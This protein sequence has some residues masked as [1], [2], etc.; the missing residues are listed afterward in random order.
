MSRPV[1]YKAIADFNLQQKRYSD[2]NDKQLH[3][4]IAEVK[5]NHSRAGEVM[6]QGHLRAQGIHVQRSR[7]R[8]AIHQ[9]DPL[10]PTTRRR[11][12]IRRRV[13][14]VPCPNYLWHIDGNH[15]LI[16][17]RMVIHH[18]IDG[19][20]R[21]VVFCHCS[22]NNKAATVLSLFQE[23]VRKYGRPFRIRTDLGGENV[24]VWTDMVNAWGEDSRSVVVG[25]SV[26]NQRIER[27]NRAINEQE[28][29]GLKEE[30]YDLESEGL[31]DPLN[32]TDIFCLHYIY[33]P[34][35]NQ[36]ISEFVEAH[37]NHGVSTEAC[38]TPAQIFYLNLHLTAFRVG[39]SAEDVWAGVR[40]EDLLSN[41]SLP[42]VHVP[43][44]QNPLDDNTYAR[45]QHEINPLS[46]E[47]GK[48]LYRRT[49][50]FVGRA[51]RANN[52]WD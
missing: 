5:E 30:F 50:E 4:V 33:I 21:L 11:P 49:V 27:H 8:R 47:S 26:H 34:R 35:I 48:V 9:A 22:A 36:R 24:D 45:L 7:V 17:W 44:T 15:K 51:M 40:V 41:Q 16:R 28:L 32:D 1:I 42:H 14:S 6:L 31:L 12:P 10:G 3:E 20:S 37:N 23:A 19:F 25:S 29:L 43:E 13:Y 46:E 52:S 18:A 39:M 38:N 2:I